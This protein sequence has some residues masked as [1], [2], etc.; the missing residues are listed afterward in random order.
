MSRIYVSVI[1]QLNSTQYKAN[2]KYF[3]NYLN[4]AK[5]FTQIFNTYTDRVL[6]VY[7]ILPEGQY[8]KVTLI[9]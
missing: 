1:W 4:Y 9:V 3:Y 5:A 8:I 2:L 6:K 7:T